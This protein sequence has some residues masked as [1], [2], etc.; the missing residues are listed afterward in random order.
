LAS[1]I[2]DWTHAVCGSGMESASTTISLLGFGL[3]LMPHKVLMCM[4]GGAR[5][6]AVVLARGRLELEV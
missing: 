2:V 3:D 5:R 6:V 4:H 1:V